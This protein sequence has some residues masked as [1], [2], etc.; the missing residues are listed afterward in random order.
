M[1]K[2]LYI[3]VI[4]PTGGRINDINLIDIIPVGISYIL[5]IYWID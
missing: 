2:D 1:A 3:T 4:N 5:I